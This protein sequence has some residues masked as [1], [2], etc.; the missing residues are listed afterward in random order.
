MNQESDGSCLYEEGQHGTFVRVTFH[1]PSF[2]A[3]SMV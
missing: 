3:A 1:T 2:I